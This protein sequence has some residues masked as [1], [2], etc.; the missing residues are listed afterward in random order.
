VERT[1]KSRTKPVKLHGKIQCSYARYIS[2]N[3]TREVNLIHN[4][5]EDRDETTRNKRHQT[6]MG[7]IA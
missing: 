7:K 1:R 2:T 6:H 3:K 4:M 5:P